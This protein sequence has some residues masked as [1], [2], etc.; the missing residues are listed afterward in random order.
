M[1]MKTLNIALLFLLF[2]FQLFAQDPNWNVY[3]P[4]NSGLPDLPLGKIAI[5]NNDIKWIVASNGLV[6]FDWINW[7]V[8]DSSNSIIPSGGWNAVITKGGDGNAW[9]GG[10][11]G[12]E[13]YNIGV[14]NVSSTP[15]VVHDTSNSQLAFNYVAGL[16]PSR[17]G[18]IWINS[19]PGVLS[20]AGTVQKLT[21]GN[22]YNS[23]QET[24]SYTD[25]MEEDLNGNLWYVNEYASGGVFKIDGDTTIWYH[26]L[27]VGATSLETDLNGNVRMGWARI[28]PDSSGLLKYDGMDWVFYNQNNSDLPAY[29]VSNLVIDSLNNLWMSGEGLIKFDGVNFSHY[30]PANSG[31][32]STDIRDIQ[33]DEFNN[34]WI[35]H[36]DAI[37]LFNEDGVTSVGV[38][39]ELPN[40]FTL[41][42]NYPNPFNPTT[43]IRFTISAL[44]FTTLKIYDVLGNEI[45]TL[46]NEELPAGN[47]EVEFSAISG[48][49]SGGNAYN[50]TSGIYFYQL[51]TGNF[52]ETKKMV[53]IK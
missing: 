22:W 38:E 35:I 4:A 17:D 13:E 42:Q 29:W 8:F 3:T 9:I 2:S 33:I 44:R 52:I 53:L 51:R 43:T 45:T 34:K 40:N 18:G 30:T 14:V 28:L 23:T 5:D 36:P 1:K 31:L 50:V 24:I 32:Y 25:E 20:F 41:P 19:W 21:N 15:W 16:T 47:Y 11:S 46:V 12:F 7:E 6:R 39:D 37:S 10:F 48:S 49:A 27:D 26:F